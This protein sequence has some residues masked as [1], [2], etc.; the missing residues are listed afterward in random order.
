MAW[1][2][3]CYASATGFYC[4]QCEESVSDPSCCS[5]FFTYT[6]EGTICKSDQAAQPKGDTSFGTGKP[7]GSDLEIAVL[8]DNMVGADGSKAEETEINSVGDLG[9]HLASTIVL[10]ILV[11]G[12]VAYLLYRA[13]K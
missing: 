7:V 6:D 8:T 12:G 3:K 9:K 5:E 10:P 2:H 11:I 13:L 1:K 4:G